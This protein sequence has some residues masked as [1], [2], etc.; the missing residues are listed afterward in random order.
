MPPAGAPRP[1]A[2]DVRRAR[3]ASRDV[4]RPRR[5]RL[6]ASG[7]APAGPSSEPHRISERRS[8]IC[9]RSTRC[10]KRSTTRC[11]CR[12]TTRRAASTTSP[13]CCSCRRR[14]WS[15]ISTRRRRSAAS[16]LATR[17]APV[18]VNRYRLH[19]E[20]WQGARVDELPWGTRGGLAVKSHF[21][22]DGEYRIKVELAAP[23]AEPHQLEITVDGE[24]AAARRPSAPAREDAAGAAPAGQQTLRQAGA[25][26]DRRARSGPAARI[27]YADQGGP[28]ARRRHV[29]R[30]RRGARRGH[31]A[32][33]HARPRHEPALSLVTI[34]GPYG[35]K[36]PGDSPSRR[37]IFVCGS[38]AADLSR[39]SSREVDASE[40]GCA[41]RILLAL[42]R[43]AYRRPVTDADISDLL[44][45]YEK[46][47]R[48]AT[49]PALRPRHPARARTAAGQPAVPV[50]R[51]A[52]TVGRRGRCD[53]SRSAI[54]SSPRAS[55]SSSGAASPTMSC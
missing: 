20:Q 14:S 28:A 42:A 9:S 32:A 54:S 53:V 22:A 43:R 3:D 16:R 40:V 17:T 41:K 46:G 50:P 27:P 8:A 25:A 37:R 10:R 44:P 47:G 6:A 35:A 30:A 26:Q 23:P 4:D 49:K 2:G 34:S 12:P 7:Q 52:G 29:H 51:R 33:A 31:A 18:M 48:T 45:F 19:P 11:C 13:T 15:A 36:T 55:P 38:N 5:A 39:R 1:D 24:R 21:P